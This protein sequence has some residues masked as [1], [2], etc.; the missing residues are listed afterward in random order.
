MYSDLVSVI[1]FFLKLL[2]V[3]LINK[4]KTVRNCTFPRFHVVNIKKLVILSQVSE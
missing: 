1:N 4:S 3:Y 2:N